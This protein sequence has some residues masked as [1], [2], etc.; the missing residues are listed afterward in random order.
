MNIV[1]RHVTLLTVLPTTTASAYHETHWPTSPPA[2]LPPREA[3]A[4]RTPPRSRQ[5]IQLPGENETRALW[6]LNQLKPPL[7]ARDPQTVWAQSDRADSL[8]KSA[9][10]LLNR[11]EWRRAASAFGNIP[12]RY[13]RSVHA[14]DA[15]YWQ[16]FSLYRLGGTDDLHDAVRSL[17]ALRATYPKAK[18]ESDA[19]AL[20][21]RIQG[22]LAARG[23][24][25]AERK[26]KEAAQS[27]RQSCDPEDLAVRGEAMRA[28]AH[29][30]PALIRAAVRRV[31]ARKDACSAP[32]RRV[33]VHL[34]GQ[35]N[36]AEMPEILRAVALSEA[37]SED[38]RTTAIGYLARSASEVAVSA[39]DAV[40]REPTDQAVQEAAARAL[41]I[42]PTPRA[43]QAVRSLI[44]RS[45]APEALR[46]AAVSGFENVERGTDIDAAYLRAVYKTID[47]VQ[48][49][50][51]IARVVGQLGG[52]ANDQWL[53]GLM[54]NN[55]EPLEARAAALRRIASRNLPITDAVTLYG[56]VV[57]RPL[58]EQL[59]SVF[60]ERR[61]PEATEKLMEIVKND[62]DYNLRR[63]AINALKRKNDPRA[64]K[65]LL[66][67][68]D[69]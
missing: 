49:K 29:T 55:D 46:L 8:Y 34:L 2:H 4:P 68:I 42:N 3:I 35:S 44:E 28:L 67:I 58:R 37:E 61:E 6:S 1:L 50:V 22:T 9:Y 20:L 53:M 43:R 16:A 63:Q 12:R 32:L 18:S 38:V 14:G 10:E 31:L 26:V 24:K 48:V 47:N 51:R 21:T 25:D 41:A 54:R 56:S 40:L 52:A 36:D 7:P 11:G 59:I 23:D 15:L 39:L 65:L 66:E 62:T 64:T 27:G 33:S 13:P 30:A 5:S 57:D 69:R 19:S 60:A 45:D 17:E